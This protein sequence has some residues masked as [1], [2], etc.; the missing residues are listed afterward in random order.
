MKLPVPAQFAIM[1]LLLVL[2]GIFQSWSVALA[3]LNLCLI[4]SVMALGVNIQWGYAGLFN[5]GIM[6]FA[7][8]GGVGAM[9]VSVPP[10]REAWAAGGLQVIGSGLLVLAVIA[11]VVFARRTLEGRTRSLATV[12]LVAG[13]YFLVRAVFDPA[14]DAIEAVDPAKSGFLGGLGLPIIFSWGIGGVFAAGAAWVVGKI[15]LGLRSDYLAIATLGIS[16]IIIA[17]LKNEDWL[18]RGVKN[19]SG[20]P[21]PVPLEINLIQS[22][23][24]TDLSARIGADPVAFAG[25]FVKLCYAALFTIVLLAILW[26]SQ[27]ALH[28]PWGRMMR[29]IRDN[30]DAAEAMGKDVTKRHL[31]TFVLGS[32]VVGIA[33]AMLVTI[34]GQFTPGTYNPLRY[35]FL[36]WVMVIVGGSG[37]NYGSVLGGFLIWFLWIQA[38]PAGLWL[39]NVLTMPLAEGSALKAHLLQAA[40]HLRL[41]LMGL[42]LLLVLRFSPRGLIPEETGRKAA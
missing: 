22:P 5:V 29:A 27:R 32:A 31:Q 9:L 35:T 13:G 6:G 30:R 18:T 3:I 17:I 7:A 24:F 15:A 1:G 25:I 41:F 42:I 38:E 16:E 28:S 23:W 20:L 36:I 19:V 21:R 39:M 33:G 14:V 2:V 10:V 11:A 37:N 40:P 4:S 26:L 34:D 12:A 8:L